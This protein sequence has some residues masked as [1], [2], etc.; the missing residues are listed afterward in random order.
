[1]T[2]EERLREI[3]RLLGDDPICMGRVTSGTV[4]AIAALSNTAPETPEDDVSDGLG[5]D[6]GKTRGSADAS[7]WDWSRKPIQQ[8]TPA[9]DAQQ[10]AANLANENGSDW[11]LEQKGAYYHGA[12]DAITAERARFHKLENV[13]RIADELVNGGG[14]QNNGICLAVVEK[15]DKS[16]P[17]YRLCAALSDINQ[18]DE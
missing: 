14:L 2:N 15:D 16:D 1:M 4:D 3:D 18:G 5:N 12:L 8:P 10:T 6:S 7:D 17:H 9:D 13:A 11:P